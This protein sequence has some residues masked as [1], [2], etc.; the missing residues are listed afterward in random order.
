[1]SDVYYCM[2]PLSLPRAANLLP[3]TEYGMIRAASAIPDR[4]VQMK[5]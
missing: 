2:N 1:M 5:Q 3:I 4:Q